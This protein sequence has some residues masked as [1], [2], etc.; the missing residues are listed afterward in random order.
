MADLKR[1]LKTPLNRRGTTQEYLDFKI[2]KE[3]LYGNDKEVVV[4]GNTYPLIRSEANL[5]E[6]RAILER[7]PDPRITGEKSKASGG[8][9]GG[10]KKLDKNKD[11][12][13][14]GA[15]FAMMRK[16]GRAAKMSAE[17]S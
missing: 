17:K 2:A 16:G 7:K 3:L 1:F 15:D 12:K 13:I 11:G 4:D 9:V 10:Q 6:A 14:S 8:L 5:E